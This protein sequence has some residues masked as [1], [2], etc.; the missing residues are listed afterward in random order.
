MRLESLKLREN[1]GLKWLIAL[2]I[3]IFLTGVLASVIVLVHT[4]FHN[5]LFK[6]DICLGNA[7]VAYFKSRASVSIDILRGSIELMVAV[8]TIGGIVVALLSYLESVNANALTNHISHISIFENF[9]RRE[10]ETKDRISAKSI[11]IYFWYGL[12][13]ERSRVGSTSISEKY[14]SVV[15]G[16]AGAMEQS[17]AQV[18]SAG[19][20]GFSFVQHQE[21][22]IKAFSEVG[23]SV[24]RHP[25]IDFYD[26]E[27]QLIVLINRV[28]SAFCYGKEVNDLPKR[29]YR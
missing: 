3:V 16:I 8:A 10:V 19:A 18:K 2:L 7:C 5:D 14:I 28:N 22:M 20:Q 17:N 11:N 27:E 25:R 29:N 23:I 24:T 26:V 6:R 15:N 12:I 1:K 9:L 4:G 21:R 13:F